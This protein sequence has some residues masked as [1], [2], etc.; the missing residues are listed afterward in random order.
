[1]KTQKFSDMVKSS[2]FKDMLDADYRLVAI[3]YVDRFS[4]TNPEV[5]VGYRDN[6]RGLKRNGYLEFP[7]GGLKEGEL[8]RDAAIREAR[9]E[10]GI[11]TSPYENSLFSR[12]QDPTIKE[13]D[14]AVTLLDKNG[15]F[16]IFSRDTGKG[17]TG[18]VHHLEPYHGERPRDTNSDMRNPHFKPLFELLENRDQIMPE[19]RFVLDIVDDSYFHGETKDRIRLDEEDF[20]EMM[21]SLYMP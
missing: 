18:M 9:E 11:H 6:D 1:M 12:F 14:Q 8:T 4:H 16:W 2:D 19:V 21:K 20:E 10:T 15:R 7:C 17:H 13:Y 5:V 3:A